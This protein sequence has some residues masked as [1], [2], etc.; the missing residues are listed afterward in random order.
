MNISLWHGLWWSYQPGRAAHLAHLLHKSCFMLVTQLQPFDAMIWH[1]E[2]N[3]YLLSSP[4]IHNSAVLDPPRGVLQS[5]VQTEV[6][7]STRTSK[8]RSFLEPIAEQN[9]MFVL[10]CIRNTIAAWI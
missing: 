6:T 4:N 9:R 7:A 8:T 3:F 1:P 2:S 10:L 5:T